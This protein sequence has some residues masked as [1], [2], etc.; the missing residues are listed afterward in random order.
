MVEGLVLS[1]KAKTNP[2]MGKGVCVS[3]LQSSHGPQYTNSH[4]PRCVL[5]HSA[6]AFKFEK[7]RFHTTVLKTSP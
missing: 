2:Y 3:I 5:Q 4:L 1:I 6:C 7:F